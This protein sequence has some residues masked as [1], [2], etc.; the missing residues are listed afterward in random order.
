MIWTLHFSIPDLNSIIID[1]FLQI[2]QDGNEDSED[3]C[4][5][6]GGSKPNALCQ[7]P[8]NYKGKLYEGC[9]SVDHTQNWCATEVGSNNSYVDDK[10]GNCNENCLVATSNN[11]WYFV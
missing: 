5:T 10:W 1:F 9:T 2:N 6:N 8:F 11:L 7:F 4:M 3:R